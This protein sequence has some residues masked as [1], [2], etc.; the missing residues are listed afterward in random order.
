QGC[1]RLSLTRITYQCKLIGMHSFA[2]YL[3]SEI[4]RGYSFS[5][6]LQGCWLLS[7]T[8]ITYQCKLIGMHSFAAYL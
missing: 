4:Y 2:A 8:R 7:L 5:F 6:K 3:Q 1:C